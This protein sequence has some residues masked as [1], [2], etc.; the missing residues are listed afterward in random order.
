M[1][2]YIV[3]ISSPIVIAATCL[4]AHIQPDLLM[5]TPD[6]DFNHAWVRKDQMDSGLLDMWSVHLL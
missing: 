2:P 6:G 1:H 5:H 3:Q 4:W